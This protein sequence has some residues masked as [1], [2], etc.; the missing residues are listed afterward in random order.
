MGLFD[1]IKA[2]FPSQKNLSDGREVVFRKKVD[3]KKRFEVIRKSVSGTMSTFYM[4]RDRDTDHIIGLKIADSSKTEMFE[5]RFK[6]LKKPSEGKIAVQIEHPHVVK[7]YEYGTTSNGE[8]YMVMEFLKGNGMHT[9]IYD[10]DSMLE[11][12]RLHLLRQMAE[13]LAAV[14]ESGF[15]HRDVCPRNYIC[16]R[17]CQSAKL[18]DFGLSLPDERSFHQPGNRTGTPLYMAPEIIRRKWTDHRVDVF[19]MGVSFYQL[20]TF[21]LPWP[22]S[23][24]TGLAALT[25]DTIPPEDILKY[26]SKLHPTLA[27]AIM[28]CLSVDP[29]KRYQTVNDFLRAIDGLM[30]EDAE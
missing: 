3:I 8:S 5:Q 10:Q 30:S 17:D 14:H 9:M 21:H 29:A 6:T 2:L 23:D 12:R 13:A 15:I 16:S 28:K 20:C 27:A 4:A 18:F 26:R 11:G 22:S 7:T 25:H 1:S 24:N 19:A